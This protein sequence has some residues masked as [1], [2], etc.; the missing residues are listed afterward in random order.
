MPP[1]RASIL[2]RPRRFSFLRVSATIGCV[3]VSAVIIAKNE[4]H[5]IERALKSVAWADERVVVD[6]ESTDRTREI[7]ASCG[8]RVIVRRW[9]GFAEQKKFAT[10]AAAN[11]WVFSL[12]AD[13]EVSLE[14]QAEI[15]KIASNG[16]DAN[17]YLIP[18]LSIYMGREIRHSG[19]YP[20]KQLRFFDR[21]KGQWNDRLVHE[22]VKMQPGCRIGELKSDIRHFSIANAA[23]HHRL[24]GER[25]APLGAKQMFDDGRRTSALNLAFAGPT[26]FVRTFFF[27]LGFLDGLPGF[28]IASFA[29]HHAFLKHL[30]LW[31]MQNHGV[32]EKKGS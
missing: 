30:L 21:Q 27:K 6:A 17:A 22:S 16:P 8:A 4:E 11:D 31:E 12:D 29:A 24:I 32:H 14:L 3:K 19:W 2:T 9:E 20:D 15:T 13:E 23:Y 25:Y 5:N 26:A 18:R 10:A 1:A 28:A 7:A